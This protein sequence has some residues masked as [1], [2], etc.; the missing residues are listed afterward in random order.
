MPLDPTCWHTVE[1]CLCADLDRMS[2]PAIEEYLRRRRQIEAATRMAEWD[3]AL[4]E[5][6]TATVEPGS[7]YAA[8]RGRGEGGHGMAEPCD[9]CGGRRVITCRANRDGDCSWNGCPQTRD[10]EPKKSGRHCPRDAWA[11]RDEDEDVRLPPCPKCAA[12]E[13]AK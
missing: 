2:I 5:P 1:A 11:G 6:P 9:E 3:K 10:G 7:G 4:R 12:P 13:A 8:R